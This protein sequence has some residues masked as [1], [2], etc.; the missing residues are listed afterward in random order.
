MKSYNFCKKM[1][2]STKIALEKYARRLE[3]DEMTVHKNGSITLICADGY[4]CEN[5]FPTSKELYSRN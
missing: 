1:D 3:A 2:V 4:I 5:Y